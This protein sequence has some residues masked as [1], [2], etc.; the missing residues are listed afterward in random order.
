[1]SLD[2]TSFST[3]PRAPQV[4]SKILVVEDSVF[5]HQIYRVAFRKVGGCEVVHVNNGAEALKAIDGLSGLRLAIVDLNMPQ[6]NGATFIERMRALPSQRY[7][8][9]L[10]ATTESRDGKFRRAIDAP[11]TVYLKK[12][13]TLEQL[14]EV[15]LRL[16]PAPSQVGS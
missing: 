13:F 5:V 9:V 8:Q 16:L 11:N 7:T 14:V 15:L 3:T 12:P 6:M 4:N 2:M 1:M 10:V